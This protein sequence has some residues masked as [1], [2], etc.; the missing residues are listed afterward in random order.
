MHV[1]AGNT[2]IEFLIYIAI[3][4]VFL[5]FVSNVVFQSLTLKNKLQAIEEVSQ[6]GRLALER[7]QLAI[8]NADAVTTPS[9][10]AVAT[11]LILQ[12]PSTSVS[13][14]KFFL[15]NGIL[16]MVE[17][18]AATTTLTADEVAV[19]RLIFRNLSATGTPDSIRIEMGVSST[20]PNNVQNLSADL[21]IYGTTNVRRRP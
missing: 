1:R 4:S 5:L 21:L 18:T 2:L 9:H 16:S 12:M 15:V 17:G 7:M 3:T 13:P 8:R 14:T 10:G 19:Q 20:N 11:Q 6:N